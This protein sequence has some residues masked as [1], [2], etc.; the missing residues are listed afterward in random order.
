[1]LAAVNLQAPLTGLTLADG[2]TESL[3]VDSGAKLDAGKTQVKGGTLE[4]SRPGN[5]QDTGA[6]LK[7]DTLDA[8][9]PGDTLAAG[10]HVWLQGRSEP[11]S[12]S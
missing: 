9:V 4:A 12:N 7:G 6:L 1:M 2:C 8:G 3:G 5:T 11:A 10:K